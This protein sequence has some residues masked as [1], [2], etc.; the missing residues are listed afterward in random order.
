MKVLRGSLI[1]RPNV[2]SRKKRMRHGEH[3]ED[4]DI[5]DYDTDD[6]SANKVKNTGDD[7]KNTTADIDSDESKDYG[8]KVLILFLGFCAS[9]VIFTIAL[10]FIGAPILKNINN[11]SIEQILKPLFSTIHWT[12][13]VSLVLTVFG[14]TIYIQIL[15]AEK[16]KLKAEKAKLER[17]KAKLE[18][19]KL[20]EVKLKA[21]KPK[22]E[23]VETIKKMVGNLVMNIPSERRY[24]PS[25]AQI[26]QIKETNE[27]LSDIY[28]QSKKESN[29]NQIKEI[30]EERNTYRTDSKTD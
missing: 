11:V 8:I 12:L 26:E 10:S 29:N 14:I 9:L 4:I 24:E 25:K 22:K 6:D 27:K 2:A 16:E 7:N 28:E 18:E 1:Q 5:D 23:Q 13:G 21:E 15:Q 30:N 19:I 17:E 3:F 20:K